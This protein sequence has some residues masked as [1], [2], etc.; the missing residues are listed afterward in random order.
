M[1]E[2]P[3]LLEG[4]GR[5]RGV[6]L[7]GVDQPRA[8]RERYAA[9]TLAGGRLPGPGDLEGVALSRGLARAL[10]VGM[11]NTVYMYAPGTEGYGASAYTVVGLLALPGACSS[12]ACR[13][14]RRTNSRHRAR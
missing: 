14:R 7:Q 11:G 13:L 12:R 5:S 1:L 9:D 10:G 2:V 4:D 8:M 6:V 3:G